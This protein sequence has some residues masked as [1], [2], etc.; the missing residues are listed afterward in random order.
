MIAIATIA[1]LTGCGAEYAKPDMPNEAAI[2]EDPETGC[3]Y[4]VYREGYGQYA[5]GSLSIRFRQDGTADCPGTKPA[6]TGEW[7]PDIHKGQQ[8]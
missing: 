8:P 4:I 3:N 7:Q 5:V 1:T 6:A 2:W